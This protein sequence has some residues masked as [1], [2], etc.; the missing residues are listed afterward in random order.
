MGNWETA[1]KTVNEP[2]VLPHNKGTISVATLNYC[3]ITYSPFEFYFKDYEKDIAAISAIFRKLIPQ[4]VKNFNE[5]TF[6]WDMG[7]IDKSFK[8]GRYSN[9]FD[10]SVGVFWKTLLSRKQF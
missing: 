5:K 2:D 9:M 8:K 7:K 1:L 3:G 6:K 4:Y 10:G